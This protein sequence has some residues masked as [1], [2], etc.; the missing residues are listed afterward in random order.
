LFRNFIFHANAKMRRAAGATPRCKRTRGQKCHSCVRRA[1]QTDISDVRNMSR[2]WRCPYH[3]TGRHT[4]PSGGSR[5][6]NLNIAHYV[7]LHLLGYLLRCPSYWPTKA[8]YLSHSKTNADRKVRLV[9]LLA[10]FW[11]TIMHMYIRTRLY[12]HS[13]VML[14][15]CRLL[16]TSGESS[17]DAARPSTNSTG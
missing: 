5:R 15:T 14:S 6:A 1:T 4:H 8:Y 12:I 11:Y 7:L 2:G 10:Y 16:L 3:Q 17:H 13:L 9:T